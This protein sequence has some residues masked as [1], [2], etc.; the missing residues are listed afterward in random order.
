MNS[1]SEELD[2]DVDQVKNSRCVTTI[3]VA[4]DY[5]S[6]CLS[7]CGYICSEYQSTYMYTKIFGTE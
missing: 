6:V 2:L 7:V 3:R 5:M 1:G 4:I